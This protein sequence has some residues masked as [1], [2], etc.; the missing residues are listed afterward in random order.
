MLP[1]APWGKIRVPTHERARARGRPLRHALA[2]TPHDNDQL[3]RHDSDVDFLIQ[4]Q[5]CYQLHHGAKAFVL[6]HQT[7]NPEA[8]GLRGLMFHTMKPTSSP[9]AQLLLLLLDLLARGPLLPG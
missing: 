7:K 6:H 1:V 2:F 5:A 9:G 4:S 8:A 3:P